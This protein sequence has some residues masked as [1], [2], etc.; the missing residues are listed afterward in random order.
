MI[1]VWHNALLISVLLQAHTKPA[2]QHDNEPGEEASRS[3]E[4]KEEKEGEGEEKEGE[5]EEEEEGEGEEEE[6]HG[7]GHHHRPCDII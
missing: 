3:H 4:S 5:G 7:H 6:G 1:Y 2:D